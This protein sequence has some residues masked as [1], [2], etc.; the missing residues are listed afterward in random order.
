MIKNKA[1][2]HWFEWCI[3][4]ETWV[5]KKRYFILQNQK[6]A[7]QKAHLFDGD[8]YDADVFI[9]FVG[10]G[11]DFQVGDPLDHLHT[12]SGSPKDC[13]LVVQPGL[14]GEKMRKKLIEL[15]QLLLS[16]KLLA[17]SEWL[18]AIFQKSW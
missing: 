16:G 6:R 8:V 10:F 2:K 17:Q 14:I 3:T 1:E 4:K 5:L 12:F 7:A 11:V 13:V 18:V 15:T 9:R